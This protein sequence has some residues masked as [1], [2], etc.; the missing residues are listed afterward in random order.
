MDQSGTPSPKATSPVVWIIL[1]VVVLAVA[2]GALYVVSSD[3]GNAN[4]ANGATNANAVANSNTAATNVNQAAENTNQANA[5]LGNT[6]AGTIAVPAGWLRYDSSESGSRLFAD[7]APSFSVSYPQ[8]AVLSEELGGLILSEGSRDEGGASIEIAR[9]EAGEGAS[10]EEICKRHVPWTSNQ[11][12]VLFDDARTMAVNGVQSVYLKARLPD[13]DGRLD[14]VYVC[15]PHGASLDVISG[16]PNTSPFVL[17]HFDA[18]V[19]SFRLGA[20]RD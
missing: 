5:N 3:Q 4:S 12:G 9:V 2:G 15:V 19:A 17:E 1:I 8:G 10:A 7:L 14:P 18:V 6:N 11:A 20:L 16:Q 13:F